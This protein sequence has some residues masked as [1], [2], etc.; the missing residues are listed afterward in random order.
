MNPARIHVDPRARP[1]RLLLAIRLIRVPQGQ[2]PIDDQM[3]C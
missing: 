3:G 1:V 2:L